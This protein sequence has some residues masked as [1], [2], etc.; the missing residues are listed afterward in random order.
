MSNRNTM[1]SR[2]LLTSAGVALSA[3]AVAGCAA[4]RLT[5][6]R[7]VTAESS[8]SRAFDLHLASHD[9][10][11]GALMFTV[12]GASVD[13]ITSSVGRVFTIDGA[14]EGVAPVTRA[15]FSGEADGG[16]IATL[17]VRGTGSTPVVTLQQAVARGSLASEATGGYSLSAVAR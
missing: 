3:L 5:G 4:D 11:A 17:W 1:T 7:S 14:A 12:S 15:V 10:K 16:V 9:S 13:S 6:P 8:V 2:W